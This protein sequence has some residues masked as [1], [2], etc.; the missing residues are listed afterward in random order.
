M[1]RIQTIAGARV[2]VC[3]ASSCALVRS[4]VKFFATQK[5]ESIWRFKF[6]IYYTV[7]A[8]YF[9]FKNVEKVA[10]SFAFER[11]EKNK[12]CV[13]PTERQLHIIVVFAV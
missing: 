1:Q 8:L 7:Y 5:V 4:V 12:S 10:I 11:I 13:I 6:D 2:S 9:K 3:E